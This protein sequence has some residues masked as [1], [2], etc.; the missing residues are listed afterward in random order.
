MKRLWLYVISLQV[1]WVAYSYASAAAAADRVRG[2]AIRPNVI[3]LMDDQHRWDALGFVNGQVKTPTL[4]AL[5]RSGIFF[6]QAVCQAPMCVPSRNAM[7]LGLYPNQTGVLRNRH[8][9]PDDRLPARPLVERFRDA[10]YQTAGFGKTHWG[11]VCSTRGFETRYIAECRERDAV[12]MIDVAPEAKKRYDA[13]GKTMGGGEE[14]NLGYLGFTSA[15]PEE[16]HRD[17]WVTNKCLDFVHSNIDSDRPLFLYLSF[18]KPHAGHN[19]PAGFEDRYNA[20]DIPYAKQPPWEKD[21]S[22]HALGVNRRDLYV[23]YW[24]RATEEQWRLMTMRYWAN[25]T[26]IDAMFGRVLDALKQK[27]V[28]DNAIIV[29]CSDHGEM[30]GERFYRFN[31]YCLYESSVRVPIILSGSAIHRTLRGTTDHRPAELVDLY[32]TL[33]EAAGLKIPR[34][35]AGLNLLGDRKR[36]ASFCALH[37]RKHEAAFMWRTSDYKLILR[38]KRRPDD[39]ASLYDRDDIIGGE[40]YDLAADP[41]EWHDLYASGSADLG[42][43]RMRMTGELLRFLETQRKP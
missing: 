39:N 17:G 32:P 30:L 34:Q 40:F 35:A 6:D 19:V 27:G 28:L 12:M 9:I 21:V 29:Y 18:L 20:E 11:L 36:P 33:L 22:P 14:N 37:E 1:M 41:Q 3:F 26:W 24:S 7:M 8:G 43:R 4:D 5:A 15:V 42:R 10:G 2:P 13:E 38:M 23:N 25:C 16:E 31:K